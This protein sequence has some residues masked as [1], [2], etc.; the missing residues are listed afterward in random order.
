MKK[1]S[2]VNHSHH[3]TCSQ[4]GQAIPDPLRQA[5]SDSSFSEEMEENML[6]GSYRLLK[7]VGRGGMG[8][9]FLAYD[10][11]CKRTV[12]L[13][14]IRGD[15]KRIR[16]LHKRFL[17]EARLTAQLY[18]PTIIP[19]YSIHKEKHILYYTMPY[20][21][22]KNLKRVLK[23]ARERELQGNFEAIHE[24]SIAFLM[25]TFLSICQAVA[26]AHSRGVLHRDLKP[27]NFL[28]GKYGQVILL[29]WGLAGVLRAPGEE[30]V[31]E[32]VPFE[33]PVDSKSLAELTIPGR[34]VGTLS[35]LAP[36]QATNA[37]ASVQTEVFALG[38]ILYQILTL[39]M[40]YQRKSLEV[41]RK[42][43]DQEV[44]R[45]PVQVAPYREVP[46]M[47][48]RIALRCLQSDRK[49]RYQNVDEL[50]HDVEQYVEGRSEWFESCKLYPDRTE[51]WEFQASVY[52]PASLAM[53]PQLEHTD[54]VNLMVSKESFQGNTRLQAQICL[55]EG[56]R[57]IGFL[58]SIP[59]GAQRKHLSEGYCLWLGTQSE[60]GSQLY[61]SGLEVMEVPDIFL[62][63]DQMYEVDIWKT[64][65]KLRCY[66]NGQLCLS[67][68]SHLPLQ[69][70]H[71]GLMTRDDLFSLKKIRISVGSLHSSVSCLAIPDAFLANADYEKALEEYHRI[72]YSFSGRNISRNALFRAGLTY[73]E[74]SHHEEDSQ[75]ARS[76]QDQAVTEFEKLGKEGAGPLEYLGKSMVYLSRNEWEDEINS[77]EL[78]LRRY[79]KHP[80]AKTLREQVMHR[81][82]AN[83]RTHRPAAYRCLLV[84][85]QQLPDLAESRH[86]QRLVNYL[87]KNWERLPFILDIPPCTP[88]MAAQW[89]R[90]DLAIR[91]A[92]WLNRPAT[93]LELIQPIDPL[94]DLGKELWGNA[95]FCLLHMG[96]KEDVQACLEKVKHSPPLVEIIEWSCK[97][98]EGDLTDPWKSLQ[99]SL[100][101]TLFPWQFRQALFFMDC[102]L[103]QQ[104]TAIVKEITNK[105]LS[106]Y[107][108]VSDQID[109]KGRMI[110][111]L[112]YEKNWKEART[113]LEQ[114]SIEQLNHEG[115]FLHFLYGALLLATEEKNIAETHLRGGWSL[116]SPHSWALGVLRFVGQ[117]TEESEQFHNRFWWEK[118]QMYKQLSLLYRCTG[119]TVQEQT[120]EKKYKD[121]NKL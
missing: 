105:L 106:L 104:K 93:I 70:T 79:G 78:G 45:D 40:P 42:T 53:T 58:M 1:N 109:L 110:W 28:I 94:S 63:A 37:E 16:K 107:M 97:A 26:Y 51:D 116:P 74:Q 14:K 29:D 22:G 95:L 77:L 82:H 25:R 83:A 31:D 87:R 38:V 81:L 32:Y 89:D 9:V 56:N 91:L 103:E 2:S 44:I 33:A 30:E 69:G 43:V 34:L 27:E 7:R 112:L 20:V 4:C 52:L 102:A 3:D 115:T 54:W 101:G 12:A 55:H 100:K 60:K 11:I 76:L 120:C 67:Y 61:R 114:Y 24:S 15:A 59:E 92:F 72:A 65:D 75:Q 85:M 6:I 96:K 57:G 118:V 113:Q 41:F 18:H 68:V 5:S 50:I 111:A 121:K 86:C 66:I 49:E 35:Y 99:N 21:E 17:R 64:E 19:I 98:L 80:M 84:V 13:K 88:P 39:Q 23:E 10:K 108:P 48:A 62:E 46:P 90:L 8:E 119:E 73:L 71:V 117:Y 36:E 47:L